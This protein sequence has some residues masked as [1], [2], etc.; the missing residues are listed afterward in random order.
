LRSGEADHPHRRQVLRDAPLQHLKPLPVADGQLQ[1]AIAADDEDEGQVVAALEAVEVPQ[2][3]ERNLGVVLVGHL[4]HVAQGHDHGGLR[5]VGVEKQ[6]PQGALLAR[7][8]L[9][10]L[11]DPGEN[12]RVGD[13]GDAG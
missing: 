5:A 6:E 7:P 10:D 13:H 12:V 8:G 9:D 4:G 1:R 3:V 11:I 2:Q